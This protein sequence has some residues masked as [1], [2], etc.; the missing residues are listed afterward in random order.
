MTA[1]VPEIRNMRWQAAALALAAMA[2]LCCGV[3]A[4]AA[5][6][7]SGAAQGNLCSLESIAQVCLWIWWRARAVA[8]AA[9]DAL[10]FR[11]ALQSRPR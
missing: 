10:R 7:R 1:S 4:A 11:A 9:M 3:P 6:F 8:L 5:P 2:G